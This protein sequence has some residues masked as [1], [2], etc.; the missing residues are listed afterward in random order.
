MGASA[1]KRAGAVGSP[2]TRLIAI[3]F[4]FLTAAPFTP[5]QLFEINK[6]TGALTPIGSGFTMDFDNIGAN[7]AGNSA[8][9]LFNIF[10]GPTENARVNELTLS[11]EVAHFVPFSDGTGFPP[12]VYAIDFNSQDRLHGIL[13]NGNPAVDAP[14][15][16][17]EIDTS[18]GLASTLV[19]LD[20]WNYTSMAFDMQDQLYAVAENVGLTRINTTAD[21]DTTIIG[22]ELIDRVS[23]DLSRRPIVFDRDGTMFVAAD[24]LRVMDPATGN[25][26]PVGSETFDSV[27]SIVGLA[28]V[29]VP[30]P[31]AFGMIAV[32]GLGLCSVRRHR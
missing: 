6:Q 24:R 4:N 13:L 17:S 30:E 5:G 23:G 22:G 2:N 1:A 19:L 18:T 28:I 27:H 25:T 16:L 32:A 9:Q 15:T 10:G 21:F 14:P 8:D 31:T 20:S 26:T 29:V 3:G 11:G 12:H 7:L